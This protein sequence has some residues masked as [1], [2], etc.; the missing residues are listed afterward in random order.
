VAPRWIET[1]EQFGTLQSAHPVE[2][3]L[4]LLGEFVVGRVLKDRSGP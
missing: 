2:D 1:K 4:L 3:W